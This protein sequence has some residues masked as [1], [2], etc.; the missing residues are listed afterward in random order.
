MDCGRIQQGYCLAMGKK[1]SFLRRKG[2]CP[3]S[4]AFGW[5]GNGYWDEANDAPQQKSPSSSENDGFLD[6]TKA[7]DYE[8]YSYAAEQKY[9]EECREEERRREEEEYERRREEEEEERRR[10]EEEYERRREE[11]EE[12]R[13][14]EEEEEDRRR[15]EEEDERHREEE[16]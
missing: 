14:R 9:Q 12:D 1:V 2:L 8:E 15:E 11:E 4:N 6:E 7:H 16:D 10:E 5:N 13:R 3:C